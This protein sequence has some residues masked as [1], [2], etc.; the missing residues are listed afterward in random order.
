MSRRDSDTSTHWPTNAI[1][2]VKR[3][4]DELTLKKVAAPDDLCADVRTHTTHTPRKPHRMSDHLQ[5]DVSKAPLPQLYETMEEIESLEAQLKTAKDAINGELIR[6]FGDAL[7]VNLSANGK[8]HGTTRLA[9]E[10]SDYGITAV[11]EQRVTWNGDKLMTLA[12]SMPKADADAT[13]RF[14]LE[15]PEKVYSAASGDTLRAMTA[16][17]TTKIGEWKV[18]IVRKPAEG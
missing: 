14:K 18:A 10:L 13:F 3:I 17:R 9:T 2:I 12:L 1:G 4:H 5:F 8:G 7:D 11:K 16:A 6:R 15:V